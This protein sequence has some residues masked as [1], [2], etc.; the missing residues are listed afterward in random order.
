MAHARSHSRRCVLTAFLA[1][2][3]LAAQE[4][5]NWDQDLQDGVKA[6]ATGHYARAVESLTAALQ[7][8]QAFPALDLRRADAAHLL[9]MSHQFQ[10]E[11]DR[12]EPLYLQAKTIR[13]S[14]GEAGRK[15]LGI[16]LDA[17]AQLR[18]EQERWKDAEDL[19]H[20]AA[21]LCGETRGEYDTCTLNANRHLGEIYSTE[22]RLTEAETI[23]QQVIHAARQNVTLEAQLLPTALRDQALI[24]VAKGQYRE[25]EPLLKEALDLSSKLGAERSE[26]ADSLVA[27]ARLYHVEGDTAR[28]EPLLTRAAAIYEKNDDPCLA[29]ALQELGMIAITEGKYASARQRFL[30]TVA[31]YQK[32]LGQDHI[33][34]AFAEV[35]LA[36]TY[37]GERNY[38]EARSLIEH[39]LVK[40]R[41]VLS[42]THPELARAHMT[43]ARISE[44][45]RL[46]SEAAAHYRQALD[47][48]RRTTTRNNP[49]RVM[50]ERQYEQFSKSFRK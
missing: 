8:A 10:G 7:D 26:V 17:I 21:A 49:V 31:I 3:I 20:Q 40:E 44:A 36:E 4:K 42:D 24:V 2:Y 37:L 9:G 14:N 50:A 33:N 46:G 16:T 35:G 1:T 43:A 23:F 15:L 6:F 45:L 38:T 25:A 5:T 19:E 47:I 41:A 13:E 18:F 12:A 32:F 28:A 48:Y 11:L 39:A 29:H 27:L 30:R 34:V 22:G